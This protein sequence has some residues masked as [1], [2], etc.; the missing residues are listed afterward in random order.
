MTWQTPGGNRAFGGSEAELVRD[1]LA[2]IVDRISGNLRYG[3][4]EPVF[5]FYV[6]L[7]DSL[8]PTEQV[9]VVKEVAEHLLS[10]TATT[11]ELTAINESAVYLIF[12]TLAAEIL[13]EIDTE[14]QP[15]PDGCDPEW[16]VYW[17]TRT[18]AAYRECFADDLD[19]DTFSEEA[20]S[21]E[22]SESSWLIPHS[23][24][25]RNVKQWEFITESLA[26][27]I[28]WDRDFEMAGYFLDAAPEQ[29][30]AMKQLLGIEPEYYSEVPVDV[31]PQKIQ[32]ALTDLRKITHRKPR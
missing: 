4:E 18:L 11:L 27:R 29:S 16:K 8:T 15:L 3:A 5:Q 28:L 23:P 26:D 32:Q 17:R 7:F 14:D 12:Q 31:Q 25:C 9:S 22:D 19:D 1:V 10:E 2:A 21:D 24:F 20:G 13:V 30:I 6:A